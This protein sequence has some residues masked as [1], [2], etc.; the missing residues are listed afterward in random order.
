M[1]KLI[2]SSDILKPA[3]K[4]LGHP[5]LFVRA[6]DADKVTEANKGRQLFS[7]A[8]VDAYKCVI[9]IGRANRFFGT[10]WEAVPQFY[11]ASSGIKPANITISCVD[12]GKVRKE[13]KQ[14]L[15]ASILPPKPVATGYG[16]VRTQ[17]I[18]PYEV[19]YYWM[20]FGNMKDRGQC[21]LGTVSKITQP[22]K[23]EHLCRE[24][25]L[26]IDKIHPEIFKDNPKDD[27]GPSCSLAEALGKQDLFINTN[28]ANAGL[29]IL[30]KMF[31]ELHIKNHGCYVNLETGVTNPIKI[32]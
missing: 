16:Y 20:D 7:Q 9:L 1:K 29:A 32:K 24:T 4:K 30:W 11:N 2:V 17:S 25:L 6:I 18:E 21:V 19:P 3:L 22:K 27:Q 23:S 13:I 10:D 26:T 31:R 14:I 5:G 15:M 12:K 8:D 28:L